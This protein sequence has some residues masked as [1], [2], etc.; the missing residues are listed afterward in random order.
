MMNKFFDNDEHYESL[1]GKLLVASPHMDDPYFNKSI[2]YICAHDEGGAIGIIVNQKIGMISSKDL[3]MD[4]I[5]T[6][7]ISNKKKYNK[8]MPLMFGGPLNTDMLLILSKKRDDEKSLIT[9][10]FVVHTDIVGF[11]QEQQNKKCESEKFILAKGVS[12]W[13]SQQLEY[14]VKSNDWLVIE[15]ESEVVFSS[16]NGSILWN[17]IIKSIGIIKP[18]K[19]VHYSGTA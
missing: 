15:P 17:N 19:L 7:V 2:I 11:L 13:D 1:E 4:L 12:A 5:Q 6:N 8:R 3:L 14:E 18:H 10:S 9:Q 16:K